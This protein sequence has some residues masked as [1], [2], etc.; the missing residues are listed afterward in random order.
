MGALAIGY[1]RRA[2][3]FA[4]KTFAF[5]AF[6]MS[7]AVISS[8][9]A[10]ALS[11]ESPPQNEGG[12]RY[13][14]I[15]SISYEFGSKAMSGYFVGQN[16]VCLV[17]LMVI[18]KSD[19]DRPSP[20]TAARIRLMLGPGQIAG[21]DSEEGRSLNFN[22][23]ERAKTPGVNF[24]GRSEPA[25]EPSRAGGRGVC[26]RDPEERTT[27]WISQPNPIGP[28]AEAPGRAPV[29]DDIHFSFS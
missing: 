7:T 2:R 21:L 25:V 8:A 20:T 18:E 19:P 10:P 3:M 22:C 6:A 11:G 12:A 5:S 27:R 17:T 4:R 15:Q 24:G 16:S 29:F 1:G 14:P 9:S 13:L 28:S 23:G 26:R